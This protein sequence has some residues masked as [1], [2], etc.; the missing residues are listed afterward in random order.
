MKK[1][2]IGTSFSYLKILSSLCFTQF[3]LKK[4]ERKN[5]TPFYSG[6]HF[7]GKKL[8]KIR[9]AVSCSAV[10]L[11]WTAVAGTAQAVLFHHL[12]VRTTRTNKVAAGSG[13]KSTP[14]F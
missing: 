12:H 5:K 3:F 8:L 13:L 6:W 1:H 2:Q 4:K 14:F 11:R 9:K 7:L 10:T